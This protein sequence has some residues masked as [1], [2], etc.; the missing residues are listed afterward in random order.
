[1]IRRLAGGRVFTDY[2]DEA[3]HVSLFR[4]ALIALMGG[5]FAAG[6]IVA[7]A[8]LGASWTGYL[9]PFA[10][11]CAAAGALTT[12]LLGRP[13]WRGRR[14][15]AFRLGEVVL[16]LLLARA[17]VWAFSE[18]LPSL[19]DLK[20]WVLA[21]GNFFTGEFIFA[22]FTLLLSWG[23]GV[24]AAGD[25]RD[26]AIQ[27]DEVAARE[28][29]SW[30]DAKSQWRAGSPRSRMAILQ[31]F[32][33][34]WISFGTALIIC[35]GLTRV[36]L[37]VSDAGRVRIGLT[38]LGL[39]GEAV[40]ALVCYFL[41]GLLLMSHGRLAVLRARW[42][43]Q[44]VEIAPSLIQRWHA[45]SIA[46]VIL[47][48]LLALLLPL[49]T[50]GWLARAL[51]WLISLAARI[52]VAITFLFSLLLALIMQALQA[53]FGEAAV[54]PP[55]ATP[56]PAPP[57]PQPFPMD[58]ANPLPPWLGGAVLWL[59]VGAVTVFLL[60]NFARTSGLLEGKLGAQLTRWRLWWRARQARLGQAMGKSLNRL[61]APFRRARRRIARPAAVTPRGAEPKLPREQVRRYYLAALK[62]AA[63][64]GAPR[65]AEQTPSEFASDL[66]A[67]WPESDEDIEALTEAF[68]DAR[69]SAREINASE[70]TDA[71]SAWQRL[72]RALRGPKP[73]SNPPR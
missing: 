73:D 35:A 68:L 19:A 23:L 1:M 63:E 34:R 9:L 44:E 53:I 49:G 48:A 43:N 66:A 8:G 3:W 47:I 6:P 70:A 61:A 50:T 64:E 28:S 36:N 10:L 16:L 17:L 60:I 13:A 14:G 31:G 39:R 29:H 2:H 5:S 69:Y 71:R 52:V 20:G 57:T 25:F 24:M 46:F 30:G 62:E 59:V 42:Y 54:P 11:L 51:E 7:R 21:P 27:P 67:N 65:R 58:A 12:G 32:A 18:G 4:I 26:L 15:S 38:G 72:A 41:A 40:A 37:A 55:E 22:A 45:S 33:V 56:T